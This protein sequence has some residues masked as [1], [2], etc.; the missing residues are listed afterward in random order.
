MCR[1]ADRRALIGSA[2][3]AIVQRDAHAAAEAAKRI[4]E[5]VRLDVRD[6]TRTLRLAAARL[7]L[8]GR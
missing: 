7:R 4:A 5:T 1:C 3:Q 8:G 2:G 6:A